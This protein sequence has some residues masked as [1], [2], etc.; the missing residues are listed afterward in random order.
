[1]G[2][3][4]RNFIMSRRLESA[5]TNTELLNDNGRELRNEV[6]SFAKRLMRTAEPCVPCKIDSFEYL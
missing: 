4:M 5:Q 6:N 1:M 3:V 2:P